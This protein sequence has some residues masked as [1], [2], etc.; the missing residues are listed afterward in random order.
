MTVRGKPVGDSFVPKVNRDIL[1]KLLCQNSTTAKSRQEIVHSFPS[2]ISRKLLLEEHKLSRKLEKIEKERKQFLNRNKSEKHLLRLS[3]QT[4]KA[5]E[6]RRSSRQCL[7]MNGNA[8][9]QLSDHGKLNDDILGCFE[10][11]WE[12]IADLACK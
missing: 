1:F 5:L 9:S 4:G 6:R 3:I 11:L 10:R 7:V 2:H 8:R 12:Y